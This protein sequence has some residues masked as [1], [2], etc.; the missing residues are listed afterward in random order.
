MA[1]AASDDEDAHAD[2]CSVCDEGG[3]LVCC[4]HCSCA[5]HNDCLAVP[6]DEDEPFA[7]CFC[8]EAGDA[9]GD[10]VVAAKAARALRVKACCDRNIC[11]RCGWACDDDDDAF[12]A[13][14]YARRCDESADGRRA[15]L[16]LPRGRVVFAKR[17]PSATAERSPSAEPSSAAT[18]ALPSTN[19]APNVEAP[20]D[21]AGLPLP[22]AGMGAS[23]PAE[24]DDGL[25]AGGL[26]IN[27]SDW[28]ALASLPQ[29]NQVQRLLA[30]ALLGV[31]ATAQ[32]GTEGTAASFMDLAR[33]QAI[34]AADLVIQPPPMPAEMG[35]SP[36]GAPPGLAPE[37]TANDAKRRKVSA[38]PEREGRKATRGIFRG[39][40]PPMAAMPL[41]EQ[42]EP[43]GTRAPLPPLPP[44]PGA[45]A[46]AEAAYACAHLLWPDG[47]EGAHEST[48]WDAECERLYADGDYD[49]LAKR[50]E[51]C[52]SAPLGAAQ[53]AIAAASAARDE[54]PAHAAW[55]YSTTPPGVRA[56]RYSGQ[57]GPSTF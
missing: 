47:D 48:P 37:R 2:L 16:S 39:V 36:H 41:L 31:T 55:V 42:C 11:P 7:C 54:P 28:A 15:V 53:A 23:A 20:P 3:D 44:P 8:I 40:K 18:V 24:S 22:A 6:P 57:S 34:A 32:S 35:A 50:T 30:N 27:P 5:F 52:W 19:P 13:H 56:Q 25:A 29:G 43:S 17:A 38:G 26:A 1:A 14:V 9:P 10:R 33:L 12:E 4:D 21:G 51:S 45:W 49:G 46:R